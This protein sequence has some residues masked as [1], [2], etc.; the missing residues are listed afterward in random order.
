M[1]IPDAHPRHASRTAFAV[2]GAHNAT[3]GRGSFPS[4]RLVLAGDSLTD[5]EGAASTTVSR[6]SLRAMD[7]GADLPESA[8]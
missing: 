1:G 4:P 3:F 6:W 2:R 8:P 5:Y 7:V